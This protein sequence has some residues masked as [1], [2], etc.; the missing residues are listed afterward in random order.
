MTDITVR[1]VAP[2]DVEAAGRLCTEALFLDEHADLLPRAL[3]R[4]SPHGVVALAGTELVGVCLT[5][6]G[7]DPLV[8]YVDLIAVAPAYQGKGIGGRLLAAA[9]VQLGSA[10]VRATGNPPH[11]AWP[12]VDVRYDRAV[13]LFESAGYR[14]G[15]CEVNMSVDL[16][17]APFDPGDDER[18]LAEQG[19]DVRHAGPGD[20]AWLLADLAAWWKPSWLAE[21]EAALH[22]DDAT[23][24]IAVRDGECLGFNMYGVSRPN[25]SGPCGVRPDAQRSGLGTVLVRRSMA[26]QR[27]LGY[28]RAE[29]QWIGPYP[30]IARMLRVPTDPTLFTYTNR[31]FVVFTK[32]TGPTSGQPRPA[33]R[34]AG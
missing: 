33:P 11:Y 29:F 5:S 23:L 31:M 26:E 34:T 13:C 3:M 12:G 4:Q 22:K 21:V 17:T 9:E 15:R 2:G 25:Y 20:A 1:R 14:R 24:I 30:V 18:R 10:T 27:R 32:E 8:G 7:D 28:T 6:A 19:I 16:E